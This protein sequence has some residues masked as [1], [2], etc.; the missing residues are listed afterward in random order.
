MLR[1]CEV[2]GKPVYDGMTDL[3]VYLHEDECFPKY[4]DETYGKHKWMQ[5]NNDGEGGYY[6]CSC[7]SMPCGYYGTGIFYTIFE[8]EDD[9]EI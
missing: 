6:I 4:M 9:D 8:D 5:V 3:D 2:C 7:D 1:I